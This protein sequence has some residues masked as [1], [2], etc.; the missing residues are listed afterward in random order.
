MPQPL[1]G[2]RIVDF[3]H[4]MAGPFAT[5]L[6]GLLGA[7]IIK[8]EPLEGD[9]FR[10]YGKDPG[11]HGM[12]PAFIAANLCK[13]SIALDLKQPAAREIA[14]QLIGTA[15]A[16]TENFRPGVMDRLGLGYEVCRSINPGIVFCSVSGYGQAGEMRDFP[17]LDQIVQATSG[18]MSVNGRPE[19]PPLRVGYPVVDTYTGTMAALA[20]LSAILGRERFG[21]G[22]RIDV[23][24]FDSSLLL[25][26]SAV[27]PY[28]V[29]GEVFP[30]TGNQG[31]SRE[32]TAE[33]FATAD[34]SLISLGVTR[35]PM[36]E[37][38]CRV[39]GRP[40]LITDPRFADRAARNVEENAAALVAI[41]RQVF[42]SRDGA[43]WERALSEA[44]AP[45][46]LVR[47]VA[48]G[49]DLAAAQDRGML[50]EISV[51]GLPEPDIRVLNAGFTCDAD[52]PQVRSG[53]PRIGAHAVEIL[54]S[55][56]YDAAAR[57]VLFASQAVGQP[58]EAT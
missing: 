57:A 11:Y 28:L 39:F 27:T 19:D 56:G 23:S 47:S 35:Q 58:P 30:R 17:A 54:E 34:G 24:M 7:D 37:A 2:I 52:G 51:A 55:L 6:L 13:R 12:S 25:L 45:C 26:T 50:A 20:V 15:D 3:T 33:C 43:V 38:M 18:M 14:L 21:T 48:E 16:V 36:Y 53:P 44:G 5:H 46:G 49:V 8:V 4:V 32:P 29:A 41:L 42:L 22:R 9:H 10:F 31:Y 40:D 1:H